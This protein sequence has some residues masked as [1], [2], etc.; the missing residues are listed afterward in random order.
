MKIGPVILREDGFLAPERHL[1][2]LGV[3]VV[4]PPAVLPAPRVHTRAPAQ[5]P[6]VVAAQ[7]LEVVDLLS[8]E[9][10][11]PLVLSRV[12]AFALLTLDPHGLDEPVCDLDPAER[13]VH[14]DEV[15]VVQPS[16]HEGIQV[17]D[18]LLV[19]R[20]G[21]RLAALRPWALRP[22]PFVVLVRAQD[23]LVVHDQVSPARV[24]VVLE[25]DPVP[26]LLLEDPVSAPG[27]AGEPA[28]QLAVHVVPAPAD[29]VLQPAVQHPRGVLALAR[30]APA[31]GQGFARFAFVPE[32]LVQAHPAAVGLPPPALEPVGHP[33]VPLPVAAAPALHEGPGH[34]L[35]GHGT[36]SFL[37]N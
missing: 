31:Q 19:H 5:L 25:A 6:V 34:V 22:V 28:A 36:H 27:A 3:A 32:G 23:A 24:R 18:G 29:L 20:P 11:R 26:D 4:A 14:H 15:R 13:S 33:P 10:A 7:A 37:K 17:Q 1:R 12:V 8:R 9:L 35:G 21:V 2:Q 30:V 16:V